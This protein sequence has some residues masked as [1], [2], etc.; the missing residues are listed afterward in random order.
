ML[1]TSSITLPSIT[2]HFDRAEDEN[3][4]CNADNGQWDLFVVYSRDLMMILI[5]QL[6]SSWKNGLYKY[7]SNVSINPHTSRG[8][9]WDIPK[10]YHTPPPLFL[11]MSEYFLKKLTRLQSSKVPT[12]KKSR[13]SESGLPLGGSE[14]T[15]VQQGLIGGTSVLGINLL[16]HLHV[17]NLNILSFIY[18]GF[19]I[20]E[21]K[22]DLIICC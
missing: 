13:L 12:T 10:V 2:N 18:H 8:L 22:Y 5:D 11:G 6:L 16:L 4:W 14:I 15:N 20:Y 19:I 21:M 17:W 9:H 7:T 3:C 1:P